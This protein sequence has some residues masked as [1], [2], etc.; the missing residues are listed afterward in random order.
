[1]RQKWKYLLLIVC[2]N[3]LNCHG[4]FSDSLN[5]AKFNQLHF[6]RTSSVN[7]EAFGHGLFY[8]LSFE[9]IVINR[10]NYKMAVQIG[11]APYFYP[12]AI[13]LWIPLTLN[14]LKSLGIKKNN[15]LEIGISHVFRYN[16]F[17]DGSINDP[18]DTVLGLKFG[19][20]R[21][22]PQGKWIFKIMFTP[23]YW[24]DY[25][26]PVIKIS[27]KNTFQSDNP[28]PSGAISIGRAF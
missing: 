17:Y 24:Y 9:K 4:Q 5:N 13:D 7:L 6:Q 18:W 15:H 14:Y 22:K 12:G 3:S 25:K 8:S 2:I 11:M 19:Y 27:T 23:L 26:N 1:M 28:L 21:Q 10:F 20:R 16:Q